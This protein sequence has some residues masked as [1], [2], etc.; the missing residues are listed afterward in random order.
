[1]TTLF[2]KPAPGL[3]VRH[4]ATGQALDPNGEDVSAWRTHFYRQ[5]ASGD[6]VL[7]EPPKAELPRPA[8]HAPRS[9]E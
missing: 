9:K 1:M 5:L 8:P 3:L 4:P 6:V 7:A 2:V